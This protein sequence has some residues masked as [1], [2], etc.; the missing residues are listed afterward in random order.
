M[1]RESLTR[2]LASGAPDELAFIRYRVPRDRDGRVELE[3]RFWSATHT[4]ILDEDG[5]VRL[6]LQHTVDVT[7][8]HHLRAADRNQQQEAGVLQRAEH[9][10]QTNF[11]LD[12]ERQHLRRLFQQAPGF[13]AVVRGPEHVFELANTAYRRLIGDRDIIGKSVRQALPEVAGQ[14]YF[15]MLDRVFTTGKPIV[16]RGMH[17]RVHRQP[18]AELE[19]V[20][21]DFLYQPLVD[22]DG[23]VSG[24]FVQG[25]DITAQKRLEADREALL[26]QHRFLTESI[27]QQ[28]WTADRDGGLTTVNQR[29]IDYFNAAREQILGSGWLAFVHPDDREG[30]KQRWEESIRTGREY[31]V[32]FRLRRGDGVYRWHL[33][34]AFGMRDADG[35]VSI[36]FGTNTDIDDHKRAQDV[37]RERAAFEQ[38][39]IGIVSHDL[40]NPINAIGIAAALLRKRGHLDE[41]QA[42]A[43]ARIESSTDRARRMIRDFLDFTEAR[44]SGRIPITPA[45]ANIRDIAHH[46]FEEVYLMHGERPATFEHEGEEHGVW[47]ADRIAQVIGNLVSNAFQHGAPDGIVRV[48]TRGDAEAITIEVQNE[49][50]PIPEA[51]V[52]RLFRPFERGGA[53]APSSERSVGLGLYISKQIV[54]AHGGTIAV[55]STSEEGTIFT[56][57][58]P[59][60][61]N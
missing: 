40:R 9:V 22:A 6:I 27:P 20:F 51:D 38:Q 53:A 33:G 5:A 45:A 56:V 13:V 57:H 30:C 12:A 4:P 28:V 21:V 2:V 46:V 14:G 24:I 54:A 60:Y 34:R 36:W 7:E 37:L 50:A 49:G 25:H 31:E 10:Q 32:E 16:G 35:A 8:L 59:R 11:L 48:R 41:L 17:L 29:V 26:D 61:L 47:D 43:V 55:R 39:L 58:L 15:E 44:S 19:D 1:L 52:A 18:G 42:K 3:E 23:D